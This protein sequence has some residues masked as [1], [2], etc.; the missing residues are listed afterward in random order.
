[1]AHRN[2]ENSGNRKAPCLFPLIQVNHTGAA[3]APSA[4]ATSISA[5]TRRAS[6]TSQRISDG[7]RVHLRSDGPGLNVAGALVNGEDHAI[8]GHQTVRHL[9]GRRHSA[10]AEQAFA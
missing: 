7:E 1:M 6:S 3:C 9:E 4:A 8:L 2:R 5:P 10:L